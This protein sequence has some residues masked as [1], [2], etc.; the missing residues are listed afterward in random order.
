MSDHVKTLEVLASALE[1]NG[2]YVAG[3]SFSGLADAIR[4]VLEEN[5]RLKLELIAAKP[6]YSRRQLEA[7]LDAA[8][9]LH[10]Q[11]SGSRFCICGAEWDN[12]CINPTVEALRGEK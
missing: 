4:A 6:L 9:A 1:K 3:V 10:V 7:R 2:H 8:L 5:E 12:G 11:A